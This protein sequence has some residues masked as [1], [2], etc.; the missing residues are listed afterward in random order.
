MSRWFISPGSELS[1][2]HNISLKSAIL[3]TSLSFKEKS[4]IWCWVCSGNM[5]LGESRLELKSADS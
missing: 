5:T 3:F 4:A 2:F 1:D